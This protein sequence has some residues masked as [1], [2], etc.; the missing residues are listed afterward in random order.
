LALIFATKDAADWENELIA[1]RVGCVRVFESAFGNLYS[2]S[3]RP[4]R[5]SGSPIW[6]ERSTI[7]TADGSCGT[8]VPVHFSESPGRLAPGCTLGQHTAALLAELGY[9]CDQIVQLQAD[10]AVHRE[11]PAYRK[12]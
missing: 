7:P 1:E 5:I 10:G 9:S 12:P 6:S 8:G 2:G 11:D 3:L 4:T